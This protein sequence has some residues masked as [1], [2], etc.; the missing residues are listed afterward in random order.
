MPINLE[1]ARSIMTEKGLDAILASSPENF[2]YASDLYI[3]FVDR[4]RGF[5]SG[6]GS[7]VLIPREGDMI[8]ST[9]A[10]DQDLAKITSPIKDQRYTRTWAYFR[11]DK[12]KEIE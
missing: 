10:L 7:F 1:R 9:T 2:F 11:R 5:L 4:F 6:F 3:P 12:G 8:L